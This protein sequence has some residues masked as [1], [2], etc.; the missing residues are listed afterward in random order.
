MASLQDSMTEYRKLLKSGDVQK[1]YRGL[2]RY[3]M[4]LRMHFKDKYPGYLIS[5]SIYEG[6][7]DMTYFSFFPETLKQRNLKIAI[8]FLHE[9]FQFEVWLAGFNKKVQAEYLKLFREGGWGRYPLAQAASGADYIMK[10]VLVS[11]PDFNDTKSLTEQI[12]QGT[13]TFIK[14]I[15]DSLQ[16]KSVVN[17]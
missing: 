13:L 12:E 6:Y 5:G 15:E 1:A 7:M 11:K 4:D 2:M 9:D 16:F 14:D 3:I 10:S 8:V 17:V